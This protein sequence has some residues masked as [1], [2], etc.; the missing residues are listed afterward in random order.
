VAKR[1]A[2]LKKA[3]GDQCGLGE[4]CLGENMARGRLRHQAQWG[5]YFAGEG[6]GIERASKKPLNY[7]DGWEQ[8]GEG[9]GKR[10]DRFRLTF[11]G[12][13]QRGKPD[14]FAF[15]FRTSRFF[16]PV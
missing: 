16:T 2:C 11:V 7:L 5:T 3:K 10:L 14:V 4:G 1:K 6:V 8:L 12:G 13:V 9:K 15:M